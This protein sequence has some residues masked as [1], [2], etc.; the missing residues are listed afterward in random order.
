MRLCKGKE[1]MIF[2]L[3]DREMTLRLDTGF[4]SGLR[5]VIYRTSR[6]A[7]HSA[8][9]VSSTPCGCAV[10]MHSCTLDSG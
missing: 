6:R 1:M 3:K 9:Y 8:V 5:T 7:I 2:E 10:Y 4:S